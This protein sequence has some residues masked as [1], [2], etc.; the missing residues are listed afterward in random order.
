MANFE[1]GTWVCLYRSLVQWEWYTD[2][3]TKALF[4]HCLIRA[5]HS[6]SEWKGITIK[7]GEFVTSL[8]K[9]STELGISVKT[10]RTS[11]KRLNRTSDVA[12]QGF[13]QHTVI[14][15][16]NYD[17]YQDRA[18]DRANEGQTKGKR[19]ATSNNTNNTNNTNNKQKRILD[20]SKWPY[21]PNDELL[22]AWLKS[23]KSAKGSISQTAINTVGKELHKA[24]D[25]GFTVEQCLE[26]AESS[27]WR[28][29]QSIW[30]K[31]EQFNGSDQRNHNQSGLINRTH[32]QARE[33]IAAIDAREA[34]KDNNRAVGEDDA[35][36]ST[37][38]GLDER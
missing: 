8:G 9:L 1:Y 7:R 29:F 11:L 30:M 25:L 15:V 12:S 10:I 2:S 35:V 3:N 18:S 27:K 23:K 37:Q 14:K 13:T 21:R 32:R 24:V 17:K 31:G 20:Y 4:I 19:R 5:N 28:G 33:D 34:G 36:V 16:I 38:M 6:D 22:D 26:K